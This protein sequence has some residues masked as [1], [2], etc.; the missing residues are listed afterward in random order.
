MQLEF[1]S[2][3]IR[4]WPGNNSRP[5]L[6]GGPP[7][8]AAP[9]AGFPLREFGKNCKACIKFKAE[10]GLVLKHN[11]D[12]LEARVNLNSFHHLAFDLRE[13]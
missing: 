4:L 10:R 8:N 6:E 12:G 1:A 2:R 11:N 13:P 5:A 9:I 3:Q 7:F